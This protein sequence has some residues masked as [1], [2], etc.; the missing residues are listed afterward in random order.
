MLQSRQSKALSRFRATMWS[1]LPGSGLA[2]QL[3]TEGVV[4]VTRDQWSVQRG[5]DRPACAKRAIR[6][7]DFRPI[8][9]GHGDP[10]P[11]RGV[12]MVLADPHFSASAAASSGSPA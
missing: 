9:T 1:T 4:G 2:I 6:H 10:L 5:T 12:C 11:P 3:R 8:V 7:V